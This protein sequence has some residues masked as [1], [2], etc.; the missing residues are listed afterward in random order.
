MKEQ[1]ETLRERGLPVPADSRHSGRFTKVSRMSDTEFFSTEEREE[2][3]EREG[4]EF[5]AIFAA[6]C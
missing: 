5:F 6:F 1:V 2:R 3:E 4:Y